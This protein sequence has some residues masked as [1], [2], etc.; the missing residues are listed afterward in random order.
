[1]TRN[2][3]LVL[4]NP[5]AGGS[6]VGNPRGSPIFSRRGL[7][8]FGLLYRKRVADEGNGMN[9]KY[10]MYCTVVEMAVAFRF[11][12]SMGRVMIL[13]GNSCYL[14]STTSCSMTDDCPFLG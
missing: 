6:T 11:M 2:E 4:G 10:C 1:M 5:E 14:R 3:V 8:V 12:G 9:G 13:M 7:I